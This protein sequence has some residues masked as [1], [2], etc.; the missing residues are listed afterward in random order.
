MMKKLFLYVIILILIINFVIAQKVIILNFDYDNGKISFIDKT[1]KTGY[2][3]D[4]K[5]TPSKGYKLVEIS[6]KYEVLYSFNFEVPRII[7]T[8]IS[9]E[10]G[11]IKGNMIVLNE[12]SFS[13]VVPYFENL[14]EIKILDENQDELTTVNF[15]P[16]LS[17]SRYNLLAIILFIIGII[18]V[19]FSIKHYHKHRRSK[20]K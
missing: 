2:F 8:D 20:H 9:T 12:T 6:D 14:K 16:K 1:I 5:I 3:P 15:A 7:F 11:E 17:P 18:F 10:Y 19:V 4:R 13:L